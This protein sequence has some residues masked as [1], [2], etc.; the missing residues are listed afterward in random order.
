MDIKECYRKMGGNFDDVMQRLG[1]E[2]FI[3]RFVIR[4]LDDP[5]FQMIKDGIEKKDAELAFRGA[6]TLKGVCLNLGFS[7]LYK[8]SA[9]LTEVLREREIPDNADLYQKVKEQYEILTAAIQE[10]EA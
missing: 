5:S 8:A 4:F 10:L 3:Q 7:E 2:S 9:E 6:H 1:N